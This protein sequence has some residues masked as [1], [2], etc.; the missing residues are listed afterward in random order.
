MIDH[1]KIKDAIDNYFANTPTAKIIENLDRHSADRDKDLD[2]KNINHETTNNNDLVTGNLVRFEEV[3]PADQNATFPISFEQ[4]NDQCNLVKDIID[5]PISDRNLRGVELFRACLF[6][7]NLI[8]ADLSGSNLTIADLRGANLTNANLTSSNLT[9]ANLSD[10]NLSNADLMG[11]NLSGTNLN[12][13]NVKNTQFGANLGIHLSLKQ[14]LIERGAIF[15]DAPGDRSES[16][17]LVS[18]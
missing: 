4:Y 5:R 16:R 2:R 7:A 14:N 3:S 11:A 6:D 9:G 13:T 18:S 1:N 15:N 10:A 12:N 17:N 8:S